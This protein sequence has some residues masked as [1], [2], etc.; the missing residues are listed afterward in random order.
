MAS[1]EEVVRVLCRIP[2]PVWE[3]FVRNEPEWRLTAPV[4]KRYGPSRFLTFMVMAG[5]TGAS[6]GAVQDLLL[7]L[8]I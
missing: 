6:V 2:Y 3:N 5:V 1:M 7:W 4:L 8:M